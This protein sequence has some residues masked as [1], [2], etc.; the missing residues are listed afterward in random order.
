MMSSKVPFSK[1]LL[2]AGILSAIVSLGCAEKKKVLAT[3]LVEGVVTLD[4]Q[5]VAGATL[6]FVPVQDGVGAAATGT[7]DATGKYTLTAV[8]AGPGAKPGAG[9]LP[10]EYNVGV[11]KDEVP[12]VPGSGEEGYQ[13]PAAD[14]PPSALTVTHV[15]PQ[16]FNDPKTSGIPKVTV[17]AG[18]NDI[19]IVL[20]SK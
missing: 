15:V 5:P 12:D 7:S 8:G 6:T 4:G 3:E 1:L 20:K 18:K 13:L 11:L 19:A 16:Q 9:T 2:V 14:Q 10:G 17:K